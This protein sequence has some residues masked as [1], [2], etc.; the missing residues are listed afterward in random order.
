[1]CD[2]DSCSDRV[3]SKIRRKPAEREDIWVALPMCEPVSCGIEVGIT[4][5]DTVVA[6]RKV[7]SK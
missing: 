6:S 5:T 4:T 7:P 2:E 3:S 1:M